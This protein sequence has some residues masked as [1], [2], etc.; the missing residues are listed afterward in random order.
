MHPHRR[1]RIRS[2]LM[3]SRDDLAAVGGDL[4][5]SADDIGA[6]VAALPA[7]D[8]PTDRFELESFAGE[9]AS[10]ESRRMARATATRSGWYGGAPRCRGCKRFLPARNATCPSCRI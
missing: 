2:P 1:P 4:G 3:L 6:L 8:R 9:L 5:V 10:R 7:R